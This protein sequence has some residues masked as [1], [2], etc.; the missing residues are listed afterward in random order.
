M[1]P[2]TALQRTLGVKDGP[3]FALKAPHLCLTDSIDL[4]VSHNQEDADAALHI[5]DSVEAQGYFAWADVKAFYSPLVSAEKQISRAFTRARVI[6]LFV[7]ENFRDTRWCE[8]EYALGLR[9]EQDL[10]IT[11][12]ITVHEGGAGKATIPSS[13]ADQG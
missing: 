1:L 7:G 4:V 9:S 6:C 5:V 10:A 12:V 3:S 2:N 13:L 8:E 11:R